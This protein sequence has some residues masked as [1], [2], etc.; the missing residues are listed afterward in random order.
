M[1]AEERNMSEEMCLTDDDQLNPAQTVA[2]E[3]ENAEEYSE[4]KEKRTSGPLTRFG[5]ISVCGTVVSLT[6]IL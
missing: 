5:W 6:I 3:T 2:R 4:E 1:K